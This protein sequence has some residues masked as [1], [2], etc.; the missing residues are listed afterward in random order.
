MWCNN[1]KYCRCTVLRILWNSIVSSSDGNY[2]RRAAH[3]AHIT[4]VRL[5]D[6]HILVVELEA[7]LPGHQ[8]ARVGDV[9]QLVVDLERWGEGVWSRNP[10]EPRRVQKYKIRQFNLKLT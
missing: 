1:S 6:G 8:G 10:L 3:H 9:E 2:R 5:D 4:C 7:D